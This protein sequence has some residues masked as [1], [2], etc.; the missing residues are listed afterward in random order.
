M[1]KTDKKMI[2]AGMR[3]GDVLMSEED[4]IW[5]RYSHDKVDSGEELAKVIRTLYKVY[6]LGTL[7]RALSIGSSN[8]PQFRILETAFRGGLYLVDIEKAALDI[9]QERIKRQCTDHVSTIKAD[10]NQLFSRLSHTERFLKNKLQG[11]KVNLVTLHHSLYYCAESGWEHIFDNLYRKI[12]APRSALHAVLMASQSDDP[13]TTTWLYNHFAGKFF[14][15]HNDQDLCRF[16][17]RLSKKP[18]FK[19]CQIYCRTHNVRFLVEDFLKFM[20]VIWMILLYPNVHKYNLAQKEEITAFIYDNFW[21]K[22]RPLIQAQDHLV[23]Y[24]RIGFKGLV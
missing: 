18:F 21:K 3:A 9:V 10:Y 13:Y 20:S 15:A 16:A 6:P 1:N 2:L 14:G 24:S 17:A 12:L 7:L 11:K 23:I 5:S 22:R 4:R 19:E 8:E